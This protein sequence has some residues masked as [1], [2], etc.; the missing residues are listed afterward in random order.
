MASQKFEKIINID[1]KSAS[2]SDLDKHLQDINNEIKEIKTSEISLNQS[3]EEQAKSLAKLNELDKKR[4][5]VLTT[6]NKLIEASMTDVEKLAAIEKKS[7]EDSKKAEQE[8]VEANKIANNQKLKALVDANSKG[9]ISE[10][11]YNNKVFALEQ[12]ELQKEIKARKE[13]NQDV[14]ELELKSAQNLNNEQKRLSNER[15]EDAI[16]RADDFKK[17]AEGIAGGFQIAA[18]ASVLFGDKTG[19]ELAAAQAKVVGLVGA[20]DGIKKVTEGS[21]AGFKL[22]QDG[23]NKSTVASKLFGTTAKGAIAATGIGLLLI[24]LGAVYTYFDEITVAAKEFA[25]SIGLTDVIDQVSSFL[26]KIGGISGLITV[27]GGFIK[28]FVKDAVTEFKLLFNTLTLQFDK[29][30]QNAKDLGQTQIEVQKA[31]NAAIEAENKRKFEKLQDLGLQTNQYLIDLEKARGQDTS[32]LEQQLLQKRID[33]N[34][35]RLAD[36]TKTKD[37]IKALVD[38]ITK[39]TIALEAAQ[40]AAA[41]KNFEKN[42]KNLQIQYNKRLKVI[43]DGLNNETIKEEEFNEKKY[44]LDLDLINGQIALTKKRNQDVSALELQKSQLILAETQ[45]LNE[46]LIKKQ[47]DNIEKTNQA[48]INAQQEALAAGEISHKEYNDNLLDI[49][50]QYQQDKLSLIKKGSLEELQAQAAINEKELSQAEAS[51]EEKID[52]EKYYIGQQAAA[53]TKVLNNVNSGYKQQIAAAQSL[54]EAKIEQLNLELQAVEDTNGKESSA[55]KNLSA[56]KQQIDDEYNATVKQKNQQLVQQVSQVAQATVQLLTNIGQALDANSQN[57]IANAQKQVD[58][59]TA[60]NDA[61][62]SQIDATNQMIADSTSKINELENNLSTDRGERSAQDIQELEIAKSKRAEQQIQE[63]KLND[64]KIANAKKLQQEQDKI[65]QLQLQQKKRDRDIA[66]IQAVINTA[67]GVTQAI[68]Q[69]GILG[70]I[71]GAIVAAAGAV[72]IGI[73]ASQKF[74]KGGV[75]E[76]E[77][78]ANGGIKGTGRFSNVEVEGGEFVVNKKSTQQ[79]LPL[80]YAIN[81]NKVSM[82]NKKFADGGIVPSFDSV[83]AIQQTSNQILN[84]VNSAPVYV[85]VTE[86]NRVQKKVNVIE[87]SGTF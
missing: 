21:V 4:N 78:H 35:T 53:A 34:R 55:Y 50:S 52:L 47:T 27:A 42:L 1:V 2:L 8:A 9:L 3:L 48:S 23:I 75:I 18:G 67:L 16:K 45:R 28:G 66:I 29:A 43:T 84:Q 31:V 61:L 10:K 69:G 62:Q 87:S 25:K 15:Q 37:E 26:D 40:T 44:K 11:E 81:E 86:I 65:A 22:L 51:N 12:E 68:A 57:Q 72:E 71:T 17:A 46:E 49:D 58:D 82:D 60:Q 54:R 80:L 77:S 73:I 13:A 70:I 56:Q 63:K 85:A 79:Y 59:I 41:N 33:L 64:A 5:D 24:A 74:E 6:K 14:S 83:N 30:E 7:S 32:A 36:E 20:F 76:G 39:D 38:N 19:E